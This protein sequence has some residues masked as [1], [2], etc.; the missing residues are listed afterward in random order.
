MN[1]LK[2]KN[3]KMN[4]ELLKNSEILYKYD[5]WSDIVTIY[6]DGTKIR[7]NLNNNIRTKQ[8]ESIDLKITN[9]CNAW[10]QYCH[11][12]SN[13]DWLHWIL[14]ID[15]FKWIIPWMEVA[16]GWWNPLDH[17]WL[18]SFL[19]DLKSLG[20][21]TNITINSIHLTQEKYI[22]LT[23]LLIQEEL[24]YGIGI[25]Y[26][27]NFFDK[28]PNDIKNYKNA[29]IHVIFW[30]VWIKDF[31]ILKW[32]K[33]LILWYKNH[34]RWINYKNIKQLEYSNKLIYSL[35]WKEH[36]C[37]DNLAIK[38]LK[39]LDVLNP[40]LVKDVYMWWDWENTFYV[41]LVKWSY[42]ITSYKKFNMKLENTLLECYSNIL[43]LKENIK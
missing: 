9:Y 17:P 3:I 29:V 13:I 26:N 5:N 38:Q 27:S 15:F 40:E 41:D 42:S 7:E 18:I 2:Y 22:N 33:I 6:T 19:R 1:N 35:L 30:L 16:I 24:V 34:W 31:D 37:F 21:I 23:R 28:I 20:I 12:N 43:K 36:L 25:S 10:C 11:E 8:P 32:F 39:L 4:K 14:N